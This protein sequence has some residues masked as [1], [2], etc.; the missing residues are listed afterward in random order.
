MKIESAAFTEKDIQGFVTDY[1]EQERTHLVAR[2]RAVLDEV[3]QLAGQISQGQAAPKDGWD[4]TE[5]LAHMATSSQ[6]FGWLAHKVTSGE[7]VGEVLSMLQMR[8]N[9]TADAAKLGAIELAG[10]LRKN[11]ERTV[12]VLESA[13]PHRLRIGFDY[14]GIAMTAED[15]IRIPLCSHLE[16]HVQQIRAALAS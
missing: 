15:V 2:L 16:T 11:V 5:V 7:D 1:F 9:V 14:V 13:D 10:Q 6:Y 3:D 4:P 8:D 12:A